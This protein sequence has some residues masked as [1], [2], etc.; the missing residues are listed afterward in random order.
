M[1][2][3]KPNK[4][5]LII[6]ILLGTTT[7]YAA[8][9]SPKTPPVVG[10]KP[11]Y[12]LAPGKKLIHAGGL[13][14][15]TWMWFDL[16]Q[17]DY[18]D[19]DGDPN[20]I[21]KTEIKLFIGGEQIGDITNDSGITIPKTKAVVGKEIRVEITPVSTSGDPIKGNPLVLTGK[22]LINAG[23]VGSVD[24]SG[25][26]FD[27]SPRIDNLRVTVVGGMKVGGVIEATY[28]FIRGNGSPIDKS[29]YQIVPASYSYPQNKNFGVITTPGKVPPYPLNAADAGDVMKVTVMSK[30]G[31]GREG[32]WISVAT[33][34]TVNNSGF[35]SGVLVKNREPQSVT[36]AFKSTAN[37]TDNGDAGTAPVARIDKL[38]ASFTPAEGSN[39]DINDYTF[40]WLA[41]GTTVVPATKGG[42][43]FTP[44]TEHQGKAISVDVLPVP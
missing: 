21:K 30:N 1:T 18:Q 16:K 33:D 39:S 6:A 2:M 25:L 7:A 22:D 35:G 23:A 8:T 14:P 15:G 10:F 36:I 11:V 42:N 32:N 38:T 17:L 5:A 26:I 29:M 27:A 40:R 13:S 28:D 24:G 34:G 43:T 20:D 44:G 19:K 9:I 37:V 4:G 12:K 3:L 31:D 41:D